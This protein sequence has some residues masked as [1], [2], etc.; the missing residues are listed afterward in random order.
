[1]LSSLSINHDMLYVALSRRTANSVQSCPD[2]TVAW[3]KPQGAVTRVNKS[4]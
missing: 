4:L 1:M 2:K 3:P